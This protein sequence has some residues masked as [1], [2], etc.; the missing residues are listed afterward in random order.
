MNK[1]LKIGDW[2][3]ITYYGWKNVGKILEISDS[4]STAK[5]FNP[6][7]RTSDWYSFAYLSRMSDSEA[8]IYILEQ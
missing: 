5:M 7:L 2:C 3:R 6:K 1:E 4:G 8:M